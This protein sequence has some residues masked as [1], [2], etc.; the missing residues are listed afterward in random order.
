MINALKHFTYNFNQGFTNPFPLQHPVISSLKFKYKSWE[1][2]DIEALNCSLS[3]IGSYSN[4]CYSQLMHCLCAKV[5]V[6]VQ[7]LSATLVNLFI[8]DQF[9]RVYRR[10]R[11][12]QSLAKTFFVFLSDWRLHQ[13]QYDSYFKYLKCLQLSAVSV[14]F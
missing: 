12:R 14:N 5:V 6:F 11:N 10:S 4:K 13:K 9:E 7:R 3:K 2:A 8:C 1:A